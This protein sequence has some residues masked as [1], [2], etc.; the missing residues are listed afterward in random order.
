MSE[1]K[2]RPT[3][4][5]V[6]SYLMTAAGVVICLR[7]VLW[8]IEPFFGLI[9]VGIIVLTVIGVLLYRTTKF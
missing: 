5:S 2:K 3:L 4:S 9:I 8:A 1:D 7:I 6:R